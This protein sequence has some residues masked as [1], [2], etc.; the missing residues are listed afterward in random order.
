[1]PVGADIGDAVDDPVIR[2]ADELLDERQPRDLTP[3]DNVRRSLAINTTADVSGSKPQSTP[4]AAASP[5]ASSGRTR[6]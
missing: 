5:S 3:V 6:S 4:P 2:D 1:M